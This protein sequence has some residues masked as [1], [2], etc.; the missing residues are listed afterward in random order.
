M[1]V[2]PSTP[3]DAQQQ[4]RTAPPPPPPQVKGNASS[5]GLIPSG[6]CCKASGT[7][8][9]IPVPLDSF[10]VQ[11]ARSP[12]RRD[13]T[14]E[15]D[16]LSDLSEEEPPETPWGQPQ[17]GQDDESMIHNPD[18]DNGRFRA[19]TPPRTAPRTRPPPAEE[20]VGGG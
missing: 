9:L 7:D 20:Q 12:A 3:T 5:G 2:A 1:G 18:F 8:G 15:S 14:Y 16:E 11:R 6:W 19:N 17:A 10:V 4:Q 13:A